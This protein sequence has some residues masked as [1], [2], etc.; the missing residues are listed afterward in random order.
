MPGE[1]RAAGEGVLRR[2]GK[3]YA[4]DIV[5]CGLALELVGEVAEDEGGRFFKLHAYFRL[6]AAERDSMPDPD[7]AEG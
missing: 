4:G 7:P 2:A 3:G 6:G 1:L 5:L